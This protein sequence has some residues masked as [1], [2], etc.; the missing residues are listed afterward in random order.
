MGYKIGTEITLKDF[1]RM[2]KQL[3]NHNT[4]QARNK[5]GRFIKGQRI[6]KPAQ[7]IYGIGKDTFNLIDNIIKKEMNNGK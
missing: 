3:A 7:Y 5:K 4:V 2:M 1:Q 6:Y